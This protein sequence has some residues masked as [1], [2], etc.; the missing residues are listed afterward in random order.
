MLKSCTEAMCG[1]HFR[2]FGVDN[3]KVGAAGMDIQIVQIYPNISTYI[4][5]DQNRMM[6]GDSKVGNKNEQKNML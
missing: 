5:I 3:H 1:S 2:L 6:F 4:K